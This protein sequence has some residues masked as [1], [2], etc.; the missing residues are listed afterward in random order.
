DVCALLLVERRSCAALFCF[1]ACFYGRHAWYCVVGQY[2]PVGV[3]L[4]ANKPRFLH[5]YWLLVSPCGCAPRCA[6]VVDC[7]G[8]GSGLLARWLASHGPAVGSYELE[9]ILLSGDTLREHQWYLAILVLVA[10]GALTKS[11]QFPFHF[12]LPRA[13]AAP[14]P[15]SAYLHSAT[16]VKAGV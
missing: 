12:W 8:H 6:Y 11:A 2:Y 15:V 3:V 10:L 1:P 7:N 5:A 4:G 14:T 13:M 16:M 9:D